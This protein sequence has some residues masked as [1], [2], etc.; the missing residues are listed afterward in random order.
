[1][2]SS[3]SKSVP[4]MCIWRVSPHTPDA[5]WVTQQARQIVW[6]LDD[7]DLSPR[8]QIR[9]NDNK[10]TEAFDTVFRS[11]DMHVIPTPFRA[12][13]ANSYAE[14]WI[15]SV[16]EECLDHILI[17]NETHLRN[18]LLEFINDYYNPARP[19]QG[20][21]QRIP[22]HKAAQTSS[23]PHGKPPRTGSVQRRQVLGG[24]VNDYYRASSSSAHT[25]H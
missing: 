14:R 5:L 25:I 4:A 1:M 23:F 9:D 12:P 7:R 13:N 18:V 6:E 20:L 11:T 17:L 3:L 8:F 24:I 19:H 2:C 22:S 21:D 16:R 10:F 15:R